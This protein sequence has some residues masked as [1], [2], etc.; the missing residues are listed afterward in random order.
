MKKSMHY[1]GFILIILLATA[2]CK[3]EDNDNGTGGG[4]SIGYILTAPSCLPTQISSVEFGEGY[5]TYDVSKRLIKQSRQH[6]SSTTS[7]FY[8]GNMMTVIDKDIT[9]DGTLYSDTNIH[10]LNSSGFIEK[11]IRQD[12][13]NY[14]RE[15]F[16]SYN[17]SGYLIREITRTTT[18]F[19]IYYS[20]GNSYS[21]ENGNRTKTWQLNLNSQTGEA[22]DSSINQTTTYY[23]NLPGKMSAIE[24]WF[25]RL[26]KANTNDPKTITYG[27]ET[28][29]YTYTIGA[30]GY[31]T[32]MKQTGFQSQELVINLYW[33]CY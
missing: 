18:S 5:F 29:H 8:S 20:G 21:Y 13:N 30:N 22:I 2:S 10:Y 7:Y 25:E 15:T 16:Y 33:K 6:D 28:A 19:N 1:F 24:S 23:T 26:G 14:L 9:S 11:T 4:N 31:P 27:T 12:G 17:P 3:K 32:T